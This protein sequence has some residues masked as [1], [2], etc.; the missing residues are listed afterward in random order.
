MVWLGCPILRGCHRPS[1][2]RPFGSPLGLKKRPTTSGGV[3]QVMDGKSSE[4]SDFS[5]QFSTEYHVKPWSWKIHRDIF[6]SNIPSAQRT[7]GLLQP[8][9]WF[10]LPTSSSVLIWRRRPVKLVKRQEWE[11]G[12]SPKGRKF[13][14]AQM[15]VV[16]PRKE[17][18]ISSILPFPI[19][20]HFLKF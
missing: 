16:F 4:T 2:R 15:K 3:G 10:S 20:L 9:C 14:F 8:D 17:L 6:N 12:S 13:H 18:G 1:T 11:P 5:E 19:A 7:V